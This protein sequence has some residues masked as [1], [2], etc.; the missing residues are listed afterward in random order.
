MV[1]DFDPTTHF[2][3]EEYARINQ[4][5]LEREAARARAA[6]RRATV[7][8]DDEAILAERRKRAAEATQAAAE[9][10]ARL[11]AMRA[12]REDTATDEART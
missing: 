12:A 11:A 4:P 9:N 10:H 6:A 2:T 1:K 3:P 7:R 5:R 8:G